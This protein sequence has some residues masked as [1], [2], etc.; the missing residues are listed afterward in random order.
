MKRYA[1]AVLGLGLWAAGVGV[2]VARGQ[3]SSPTAELKQ[4]YPNPF[5]PATTIPFSLHGELFANGHRPKVS[6]KIYNVLA[7]LVAIPLLQGVGE[8]LDNLELTCPDAAGC[9][10]EAYWDGNVRRTSQQAASGVYLY[11]LVVDGTRYTKKMV[12]MK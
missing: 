2:G 8:Q 10:F 11:Q 7:Q 3:G 1:W 4:N 12:V 9:S 5:N 6:L